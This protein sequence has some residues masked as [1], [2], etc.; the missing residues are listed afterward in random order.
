MTG[1]RYRN[2]KKERIK[3]RADNRYT[4]ITGNIVIKLEHPIDCW[5]TPATQF[6]KTTIK[7]IAYAALNG[8]QLYQMHYNARR[9]KQLKVTQTCG[10]KY[11]VNPEHL[12]GEERPYNPLD[13]FRKES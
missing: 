10:N 8:W 3:K 9:M 11:C 5:V 13:V 1:K 2:R 7:K 6:N 12:L 4:E